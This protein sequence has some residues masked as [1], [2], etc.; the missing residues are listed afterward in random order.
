MGE[1]LSSPLEGLELPTVPPKVYPELV[2]EQGISG[3][4]MRFFN[5]LS[6]SLSASSP[7]LSKTDFPY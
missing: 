1:V 4:C 3:L 2:A 6:L 7:P 5:H